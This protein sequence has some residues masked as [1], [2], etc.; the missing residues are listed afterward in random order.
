[1]VTLGIHDSSASLLPYLLHTR[2]DFV[3][4][5][6]GTWRV[7]MHQE[8]EVQF[9]PD[10]VGAAV[11]YNITAFGN[12]LKSANLMAGFEY[13]SFAGRFTD[14]LSDQPP[15]DYDPDLY[16]KVAAEKS[17]FVMPGIVPNSGQY[18]RS[19]AAVIRAGLRPGT[20]VFTEGAFE[21][22]KRTSLF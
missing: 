5:S 22:A 13:D 19:R 3:L 12:P 14:L 8:D 1:M 11:Y 10:E 21:T 7:A 4:N 18:P 16:Q 20:A 6:T 17:C 9:A 15:S 2:D